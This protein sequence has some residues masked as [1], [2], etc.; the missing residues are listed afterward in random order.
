MR[1]HRRSTRTL[2]AAALAGGLVATVCTVAP[3]GP[4]SASTGT[5]PIDKRLFGIHDSDPTSWPA[6]NPGSL[7]LWDAGVAW[8][9]IET[10]PG[11][12]D[13]SRLD[14]DVRAAHA[15][16]AEV[17]LVLGRTP[18]F[19]APA[20]G[21]QTSNP[22]SLAAWDAY[23][24]ALVTRYSAASWGYRGIG[25]YQVWNEANVTGYWTGTPQQMAVLT[26]HTYNV[27]KSV[28][29]GAL[30]VSPAFASRIAE[31]IR[32]IKRF[33]FAWTDGKPAWRYTDAISLNLYPLDAY[34]GVPGTP[35]KSMSLLAKARTLLGYGGV[36]TTFPI[37][38][39]EINYGMPTGVNG[40]KGAV[41]IG[42]Q[43]QMAYLLRTYL[44]NAASGIRRVDWYAYDQRYL[45]NG[46]T[47]GNVR[48][49]DPTNGTTISSAG[50]TY[51]LA[52]KWMVGA[53]LAPT[54]TGSKLC[55]TDANGTYTCVL[56][57]AGGVRRVY[58]N[59]TKKVH[60]TTAKGATYKVGIYGTRAAI[61]G[62]SRV[63]VDYRP[64]MVRSKH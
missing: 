62:G 38:N 55:A 19:Y 24:R 15:A 6:S 63:T 43:L 33:A 48:L 23:V 39:T 8:R 20:G 3:A 28:D 31:Q 32:G 10:T 36:P 44:L 57:Y 56:T 53:R 5:A 12:Y 45:A 34:A 14:A 58:W 1:L 64:V 21:D 18:S 26:E 27:V 2:L 46:R 30:V 41:P 54:R 22:T 47:L 9:D 11:V 60:V 40:G 37:W 52:E 13:F 29:R 35:E 61:K 50:R 49:S 25:A 59:P 51:Q 7:R 42:P 17:T 16:G 4:V